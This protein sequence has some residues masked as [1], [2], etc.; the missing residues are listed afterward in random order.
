MSTV[1]VFS[2]DHCKCEEKLEIVLMQ[3]LRGQTKS[4]MV[5]SEVACLVYSHISTLLIPHDG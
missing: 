1:F 5:V 2:W 3:N 4:I